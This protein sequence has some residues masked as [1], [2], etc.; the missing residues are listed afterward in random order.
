MTVSE[1]V[2]GM[3]PK[4]LGGVVPEYSAQWWEQVSIGIVSPVI[5]RDELSKAKSQ[6]SY[7]SSRR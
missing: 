6:Q 3:I 5:M 4:H 7:Q 2:V 1:G